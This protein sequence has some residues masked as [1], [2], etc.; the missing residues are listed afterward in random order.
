MPNR[1]ISARDSRQTPRGEV[2]SM[3]TEPWEAAANAEQVRR[4]Q[5]PDLNGEELIAEISEAYGLKDEDAQR[6]RDG[7]DDYVNRCIHERMNRILAFML[8]CR[9]PRLIAF[10]TLATNGDMQQVEIAAR[11]GVSKQAIN[12]EFRRLEPKFARYGPGFEHRRNF[13]DRSRSKPQNQP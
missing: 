8:E 12:N 11:C 7:V 3:E 5:K 4:F 10:A 2:L 13:S 6:L 1:D 9:I